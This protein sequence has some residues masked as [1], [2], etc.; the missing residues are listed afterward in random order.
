MPANIRSD[1]PTWEEAPW[2]LVATLGIQGDLWL[3]TRQGLFHS[4]DA[5]KSFVR[6]GS[7]FA[8]DAIALGKAPPGAEYPAVFAF[9]TMN[10]QKAIWRS[11]DAA[12]SWMRINDDQHQYGTRYRCIAADP[13]VFGRVYIGTDG[14]GVLYGAPAGS[15]AN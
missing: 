5:G 13:R 12:K 3:I 1:A 2:P 15:Q 6:S 10:G 9:G 7:S 11:D 14:R 8:P 4:S